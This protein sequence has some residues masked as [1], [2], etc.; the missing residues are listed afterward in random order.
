MRRLFGLGITVQH[1]L[2]FVLEKRACTPGNRKM[3]ELL[4]ADWEV[5]A[6]FAAS[7]V[8]SQFKVD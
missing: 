4:L 3:F 2:P 7:D 1:G 6:S 8:I 5:V